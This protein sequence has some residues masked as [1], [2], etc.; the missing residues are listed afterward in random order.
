MVNNK[1]TK[2]KGLMI[3]FQLETDDDYDDDEFS[4]LFKK[5]T[6]IFD[7]FFKKG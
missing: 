5:Y 2:V 7:L 3:F 4:V 6:N 1:Q